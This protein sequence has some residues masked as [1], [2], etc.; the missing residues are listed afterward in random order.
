MEYAAV[1]RCGHP[2][3]SGGCAAR[4]EKTQSRITISNLVGTDFVPTFIVQKAQTVY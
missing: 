1:Y 4:N 3:R 2:L